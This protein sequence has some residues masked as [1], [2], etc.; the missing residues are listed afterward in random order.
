MKSFL[1]LSFLSLFFALSSCIELGP[2]VNLGGDG[3]TDTT[4]GNV[5]T[6]QKK[7]VLIEDFTATDCPNCP[8]ATD[9]VNNLLATY[10]GRIEVVEVHEGILSFPLV[11]GDPDL[12]TQDGEDLANYLGPPSFW[13]IGAIDRVS[14]EVAPQDFQLLIDRSLWTTYVAQ[15][16]DSS[17]AVNLG[18]DLHYDDA[19]RKLTG[20]VKAN[21]L[22]TVTDPVNITVL[23]TESGI[24][25]AQLN[26][27]TVDTNYVHNHVLR[28]II[29]N[30]TGNPVSGSTT[31]GTTLT[32]T[33]P[34]YI[35]SSDWNADSCRVLAFINTAAGS[36]DVLQAMSEPLKK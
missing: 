7:M 33:L 2:N 24:V 21:F 13:P 10:P 12:W 29:T 9:I 17:Q 6:T 31:A 27:L 11:P 14:W 32:Y 23:I 22:R 4:G 3:G 26:G 36:Y 16:L 8:K 5:D 28:D 30:Y 20:S 25:A 19:T 35:V 34:T 1:V 18:F 15:E